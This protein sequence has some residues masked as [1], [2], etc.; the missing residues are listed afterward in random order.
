MILAQPPYLTY[1]GGDTDSPRHQT[2]MYLSYCADDLNIPTGT[3]WL[4]KATGRSITTKC[5]RSTASK[6]NGLFL[7]PAFR[8]C[9]L[10]LVVILIEFSFFTDL[11]RAQA[12]LLWGSVHI[13]SCLQCQI[14]EHALCIVEFFGSTCAD[15]GKKPVEVFWSFLPHTE[16]KMKISAKPTRVAWSILSPGIYTFFCLLFETQLQELHKGST[17]DHS[18]KMPHLCYRGVQFQYIG[19]LQ[20]Y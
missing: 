19:N 20:K 14:G 1:H 7:W 5:A 17:F 8:F 15:R 18:S 3:F 10:Q 11:V 6:N 16:N 9:E 2:L 12:F 13:Y 4:L